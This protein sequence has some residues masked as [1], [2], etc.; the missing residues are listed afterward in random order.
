MSSGG[1][2]RGVNALF[3][4]GTRPEAIKMLPLIAAVRDSRRFQPVVVSTG[5]HAALV[6]EVLGIEDIEP[7]V[8]F[9]L[10]E[11]PRTL[12]G[13]F[14]HIVLNLE[15]YLT[16]R[17]GPAVRPDEASYASGYPAACFVHGDTTSAAAAA[18]AS[19]HRHLP[20]VHVEAGL[21]TSDTLSPFPEEL[22]RQLISRIAALHL[23]PTIRNKA[24]L[25]KEG[26]DYSRVFVTGNTAI[27]ALT[28]AARREVPYAD[29]RLADLD[30]TDG[31][32]LVV[33]TAHRREN[34]GPPLVR[35]ADAVS[36]LAATHPEVRFVVPLHPNPA[37]ATILSTRL[38]ALQ[39]VTLV[40]PMAYAEFARLLRRATVVLTDSGGVQEEAPSLGTPVVCLRETTERQEGVDAGTVELVGTDTGRIVSAVRR[41][42]EDPAELARR[43][44]RPNPYGDGRASARILAALDHIVFDAPAPTSFGADF[45]RVAVLRA[46]EAPTR[47]SKDGWTAG[48]R[49]GEM[50]VLDELFLGLPEWVQVLFWIV[51]VVILSSIGS[52]VVLLVLGHRFRRRVRRLARRAEGPGES[53]FLWVFLVPALNEEVTIADAVSRLRATTATHAVLLVI[54]D[55]SDDRTGEILAAIDDPRLHVLT[56]RAPDARKGKAAALNAAYHEARRLLAEDD[57]YAAWTDDRVI[58]VVVDAD[59]R[60]EPTAPEA[61]ALH[62]A[63]PGIG[64]VQ[65]LVRIYNRRGLLTWA[66]DVEFSSFGLVFQA[67]RAWWGI[68]NMGGNGQFTR[69]SALASIETEEG[70]WRDRLTEDQDLGVRLIQAG[71]ASV[72]DNR[73]SINQ[74]GLNSLR[75]LYRQRVRW[76]Q[77]SWQALSLLGGV[78]RPRLP[79]FARLD[80]IYY[81]VTP[82]LQVL[83]GIALVVS[84]VETLVDQVPYRPSYWWIA[85]IFFGLSFGPGMA[86][87]ILRGGRWYTPFLAIVQLIPYTVYSWLTFGALAVALVRQLSGRTSW[88]KTP[89]EAVAGVADAPAL[90]GADS[91]SGESTASVDSPP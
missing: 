15:T 62:F 86:T 70:P 23:A 48:R 65:V 55:G 40:Q 12:N 47:R 90:R 13:L 59:G 20:V 78:F 43:R 32:P 82:P 24:N 81:L 52:V 6:A 67:G 42:L 35:I 56:R 64:G 5:Q 38:H 57:R 75:R 37:V 11:G 49:T 41:L 51:L 58:V 66:Q 46:G 80:M 85:L 68:A 28:I 9:R 10:P 7:D 3:V 34:W 88:A 83:T 29:P 31:P 89:R 30:G 91:L 54:D 77:G 84:V 76:G 71:W 1:E 19:F 60:L 50:T 27:D 21:R 73:V 61:A 33:V 87:L 16:D 63:D 39:N 26:I 18:L 36:V 44:R 17:F 79:F 2:S 72:H 45:D 53:E 22:N 14:A 4:V 8:T 74:Q 25:I 69:L